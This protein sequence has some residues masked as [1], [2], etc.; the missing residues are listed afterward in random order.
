MTTVAFRRDP[1]HCKWSIS[2]FVSAH[3]AETKVAFPKQNMD[4]TRKENYTIS[5][6]AHVDHVE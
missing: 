5:S 3:F 4:L 2:S 6:P 1:N